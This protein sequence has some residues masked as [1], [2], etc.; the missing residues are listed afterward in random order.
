MGSGKKTFLTGETLSA[1]EVNGYLMDQS[2]AS[3]SSATQ[4]NTQWASPPDGAM[5]FL[6]DVRR[7]ETFQPGGGA[8]SWV[9]LQSLGVIPG[10]G[11]S[12]TLFTAGAVA[13]TDYPVTGLQA[14]HQLY[15]GRTYQC[16]ASLLLNAGVAAQRIAAHIRGKLGTSPVAADVLIGS[17]QGAFPV[18]GTGG[19]QE[20]HPE[21]F[22]EVSVSGLYYLQPFLNAISGGAPPSAL[23]TTRAFMDVWAKDVGPALGG[24][25]T[26]T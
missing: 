3:F 26:L 18:A 11:T 13:N 10:R 4:R 7:L 1:A 19:R 17:W 21:G 12:V 2:I 23:V 8:G 14:M 25:P 15:Q 5:S 24:L 20:A 9:A 16:G 22:F 6:R